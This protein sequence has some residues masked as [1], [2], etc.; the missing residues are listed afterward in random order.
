MRGKLPRF[1]RA[2]GNSSRARLIGTIR[3]AAGAG[4]ADA[5]YDP[6]EVKPKTLPELFPDID[7]YLYR[8]VIANPPMCKLGDLSD[9][10]I[11]L[12]ELHI[13][14]ELL[15]LKQ[16]LKQGDDNG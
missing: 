5:E 12:Y 4:S 7:F 9:G 3:R 16:E 10:S 1:F 11:S 8:G 15:D 6:L 2:R 13:I 14:H